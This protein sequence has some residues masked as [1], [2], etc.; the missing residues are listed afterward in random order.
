MIRTLLILF[1]CC[2]TTLAAA[3]DADLPY[4][5]PIGYGQTVEDSITPAAFFDWWQIS[6]RRGDV[7]RVEMQAA[8]G[9]EPLLG[10]LDANQDLVTRSEDGAADSAVVLSYEVPADGAFTIV[11]TRV[12][13]AEG[14]S[15][16]GYA[17]RLM[18]V[19][20]AAPTPDGIQDVTFRCP[21]TAEVEATT[22]LSLRLLDDFVDGL[23]Y[24]VTVYGVD[25][26]IPV[27]RVDI[28]GD[29][30]VTYCNFSNEPLVGDR[31]TLPGDS[32]RTVPETDPLTAAETDISGVADIV[33]LTIASRD[34]AAGR[35]LLVIQGLAIEPQGDR[36]VVEL[37]LG[38]LVAQS[39]QVTLY[40]VG[41]ADSRLDPFLATED[42]AFTCDDAGRRGCAAVPEVTGA[43]VEQDGQ[44]GSLLRLTA[45]RSDAGV[46]LQPGGTDWVPLELRAREDRTRGGYALLVLG[47]LPGS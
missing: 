16:G 23:N 18:L 24:R 30:P 37:A 29:T 9:L 12:G 43:G 42:E 44:D 11:A 3:Q 8:G 13:N 46:I 36:D 38:P 6:L 1:C 45:D 15:S 32:E 5:G 19:T 17:L 31:F 39:G 2:L 25:G 34:G 40:M 21:N 26:F 28:T 4:V 10:L 41:A 22:V 35:Y 14:A 47:E 7:I 27:I 33:N 20:S